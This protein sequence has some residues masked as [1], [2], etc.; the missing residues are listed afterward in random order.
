VTA[1]FR[2]DSEY[3]RVIR[4][5]LRWLISD[6]SKT[7]RFCRRNQHRTQLSLSTDC[8]TAGPS[9]WSC[10]DGWEAV[11]R[12]KLPYCGRIITL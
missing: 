4:L 12:S 5:H 8:S 2:G 7:C 1:E 6:I 3:P 11:T 10:V 9:E